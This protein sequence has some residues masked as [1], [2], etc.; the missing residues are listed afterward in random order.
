[1]ARL[2]F[3]LAPMPRPGLEPSSLEL[4]RDPAGSLKDALPTEISQ[5][6]TPIESGIAYP[7]SEMLA[8]RQRPWA[9]QDVRVV[10]GNLVAVE[11]VE[12]QI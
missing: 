5:R 2:R 4:H 6:G 7:D 11:V 10:V 12:G 9:G 8:S 1:M 3:F